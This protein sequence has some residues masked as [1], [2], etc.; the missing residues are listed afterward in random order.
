MKDI[1]ESQK[2]IPKQPIDGGRNKRETTSVLYKAQLPYVLLLQ[3][4]KKE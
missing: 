3:D 4:N 2:K 1:G